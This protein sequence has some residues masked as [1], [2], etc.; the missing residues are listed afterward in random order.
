[1]VKKETGKTAMEYIQLKVIDMA[2]KEYSTQAGLLAK[3][4]MILVL[5]VPIILQVRL[6]KHRLYAE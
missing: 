3:S 1:M 6:K 4:L 2:R 5:D